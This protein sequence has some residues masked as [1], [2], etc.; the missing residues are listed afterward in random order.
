MSNASKVSEHVRLA[1]EQ[2]GLGKALRLF[3]DGVMAAAER[4][5]KPV[6]DHPGISPIASPAP[7]F[8][9]IRFESDA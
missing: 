3:P 2:A 5:L 9:P 4:G 6:G 8:D 1:A 7:V